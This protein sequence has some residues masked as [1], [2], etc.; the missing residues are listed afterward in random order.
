MPVIIEE[1]KKTELCPSVC[2]NISA[3]REWPWP[4]HP[5]VCKGLNSLRISP[6][7]KSA[8]YYKM[9][10]GEAPSTV[11]CA[12]NN[13]LNSITTKQK[14]TLLHCYSLLPQI[15]ALL[16]FGIS[17]KRTLA[18]Q[19]IARTISLECCNWTFSKHLGPFLPETLFRPISLVFCMI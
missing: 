10:I 12:K 15:I 4:P 13:I 2:V 5:H 16:P 17:A 3:I 18:P 9:W 14:P 6:P 1:W 8:H 11:N 19:A 7:L